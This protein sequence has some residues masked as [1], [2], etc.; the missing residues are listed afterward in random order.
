M[1]RVMD[2]LEQI[3]RTVTKIIRGLKHL[4]C[5]SRL[6]VG[7]VHPGGEKALGRPYWK[8]PILEGHL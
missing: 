7:F 5:G 4:S 6:R 3:Q 2:L 1:L 8:L